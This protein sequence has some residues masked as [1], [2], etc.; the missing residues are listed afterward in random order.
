M[1]LGEGQVG[2]LRAPRIEHS[3]CWCIVLRTKSLKL[4]AGNPVLP[5]HVLIQ[6]PMRL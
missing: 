1:K 6:G 5:T 2:L 4:K 3:R